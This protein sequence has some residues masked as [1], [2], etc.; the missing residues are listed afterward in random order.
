MSQH[1]TTD[2]HQFPVP[3]PGTLEGEWGSVINDELTSQ[4][5]TGV[6]IRD[7]DANQS[8][9]TPKTGAKYFSTDTGDIYVCTDG[10]TWTHLGQLGSGSGDVSNADIEPAS[11]A[12]YDTQAPI[13]GAIIE[14]F[15]AGDISHYNGDTAPY[16]IVT[17]DIQGSNMLRFDAPSGTSSNS[18]FHL[19]S[20]VT[21]TQR[22]MSYS[23]YV[24]GTDNGSATTA[25]YGFGILTTYSS[26]SITDGF[27]ARI[28]IAANELEVLEYDSGFVTGTSTSVTLSNDTLYRLEIDAVSGSDDI[29]AR[30]FDADDFLL[31]TLPITPSSSTGNQS[32]G[33]AWY[34]R[35]D[36]E[37]VWG[38]YD[39]L[40]QQ[41]LNSAPNRLAVASPD[42]HRLFVRSTDPANEYDIHDGTDYWI[43]TS[44]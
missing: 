43:D 21:T 36:D 40:Q 9:Y 19:P 39:L 38:E 20:N 29:V 25:Q 11:V 34:G 42:I 10:S 31:V 24:R 12:Q 44:S 7:T 1:P 6:E 35:V 23:A 41:P 2:N 22:G 27:V 14:G 13:Q 5:E 18:S 16:S 28:N 17:S 8:N 4:L 32:G 15:E 3:E 30:V 37:T 33:F 26:G